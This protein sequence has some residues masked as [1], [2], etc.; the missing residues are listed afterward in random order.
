[1]EN[2]PNSEQHGGSLEHGH[3]RLK[4]KKDPVVL[5]IT[6]DPDLNYRVKH[7]LLHHGWLTYIVG[8][9]NEMTGLL[10]YAVILADIA[11]PP[12]EGIRLA[13]EL[14]DRRSTAPLV[15]LF[16]DE[17]QADTVIQIVDADDAIHHDRVTQDL[18]SLITELATQEEGG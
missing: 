16:R 2:A 6:K 10:D 8:S 12:R 11:C 13:R 4:G 9:L 18:F 14:I 17:E 1:M 5:L 15:L 7:T 3:E